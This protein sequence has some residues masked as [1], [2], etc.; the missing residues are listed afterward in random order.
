MN[1]VLR[2]SGLLC[3][4][5]LCF[6]DDVSSVSLLS[7]SLSLCA[8]VPHHCCECVLLQRVQ[9]TTMAFTLLLL[10]SGQVGSSMDVKMLPTSSSSS[11]VPCWVLGGPKLARTSTRC[12]PLT[13]ATAGKVLDL[14]DLVIRNVF[15]PFISIVNCSFRNLSCMPCDNASDEVIVRTRYYWVSC[16]RAFFS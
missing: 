2:P 15:L 4:H 16:M 5:F 10:P 9:A 14:S 6:V 7:L 3:V 1:L 8:W 13:E 11:G 12:S